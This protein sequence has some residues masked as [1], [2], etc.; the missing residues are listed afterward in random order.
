[1]TVTAIIH[2]NF[3]DTKTMYPKV[4]LTDIEGF[5]RD[6]CW[7]NQELVEQFI[8]RGNKTK[9][10]LRFECEEK[11]YYSGKITLTAITN[12]RIVGKVK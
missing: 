11:Q 10:K 5:D 2:R 1:M 3:R 9:L 12:I 7:I 4:L 6:H 8:P